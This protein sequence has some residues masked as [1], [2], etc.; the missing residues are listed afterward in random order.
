MQNYKKEKCFQKEKIKIHM[1]NVK[2]T[3]LHLGILV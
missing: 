3:L 2:E 1:Y